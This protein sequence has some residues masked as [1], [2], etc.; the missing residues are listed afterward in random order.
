MFS[1]PAVLGILDPNSAKSK[2]LINMT[3]RILSFPF[4]FLE[5]LRLTFF[6]FYF[7]DFVYFMNSGKYTE[8]EC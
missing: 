1:N 4:S 7:L 2:I 8:D 3:L 6:F 5:F